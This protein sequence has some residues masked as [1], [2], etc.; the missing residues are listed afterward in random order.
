MKV[1]SVMWISLRNASNVVV[2]TF[3]PL[4]KR[5]G[6]WPPQRLTFARWLF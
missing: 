4:K 5:I 6:F 1:R 2:R 3:S